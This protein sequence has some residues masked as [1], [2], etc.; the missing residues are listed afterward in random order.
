MNLSSDAT[1]T[2]QS[3]L[4]LLGQPRFL[5]VHP[6]SVCSNGILGPLSKR[7]VTNLSGL[8][9]NKLKIRLCYDTYRD[10]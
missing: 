1:S 10:R 7:K 8:K 6:L 5:S 2:G 3:S 4:V 9:V